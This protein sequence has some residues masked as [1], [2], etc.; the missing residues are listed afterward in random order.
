MSTS[1]RPT[2]YPSVALFLFLIGL[3]ALLSACRPADPSLEPG[4]TGGTVRGTSR[5]TILHTNDTW[6]YYDPCG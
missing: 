2:S 6:G 1:K 3:F 5:L 4:S